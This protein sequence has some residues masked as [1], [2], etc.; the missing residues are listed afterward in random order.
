LIQAR[1]QQSVIDARDR[2]SAKPGPN[3]NADEGELVMRREVVLKGKGLAGS[4]DLT[5]LAP[6]RPG[7]VPA[8]DSVTYA[9]RVKRL[10]QTL[11]AGR[12]SAHEYALVRPLSDAVERVGRIH[13]VRVVLI[14]PDNKVLLSATF[15]GS[16]EAYFRVLWQ[17]TGRLLDVIYCNTVDYVTA[18]DHPYEEWLAWARRVQLETDFFYGVPSATVDDQRFLRDM[19]RR[20][21]RHPASAADPVD[22]DLRNARYVLPS[23]EAVARSTQSDGREDTDD[24]LLAVTGPPQRELVKQSV[25]ALAGLYALTDLYVP[26]TVDGCYLA[27]A[28]VEYLS[29]LPAEYVDR[30]LQDD[31]V[32]HRF[33]RQVNWFKAALK[34]PLPDVRR[35]PKLPPGL[36]AFDADDV[37]GG[38]VTP[39]EG[40]MTHGC[41]LLLAFDSAAAAAAFLARLL[42]PAAPKLSAESGSADPVKRNLSFTLEGLRQCGLDDAQLAMFPDEF[43]HGM[44][45]RAGQIGDLRTNHPRRW[46]RPRRFGAQRA[47]SDDR[48][49]LAAVHALLQLRVA[50][51]A[52]AP[53]SPDDYDVTRPGHPLNK[54]LD[55]L[56]PANCGTRILA[57]ESMRRHFRGV[58]PVE[59]FG[60][61]DEASQPTIDPGAPDANVNRVQLGEM[62]IGYANE[63]DHAPDRAAEPDRAAWLHNGSFLVVRKLRQFVDQ[64][65]KAVGQAAIRPLTAETIYAKLVGRDRDGNS[66]VTGNK[67]NNFTYAF[68]DPEG[69]KCPLHAHIRRANPRATGGQD[70]R[71]MPHIMRRGMSYGRPYDDKL[72]PDSAHNRAERGLVFMAYNASIGE[73]FEVVQRWL[74]GGNSTG[75]SSNPSD[76][77]IGVPENG[78][79]RWFQFEHPE[80]KIVRVALD[81][82]DCMFSDPKPFVRLEWGAYFFAPSMKALRRLRDTATASGRPTLA[83]SVADGERAIQTLLTLGC[84]ARAVVEW[85]RV[86]EDIESVRAFGAASVWAA[87]RANHGGVL[88]TP[89]GVLVADSSLVQRMLDDKHLYSVSGYLERMKKSIGADHLGLDDSGPGCP[90]RQD[91][92]AVNDAITNLNQDEA[93]KVAREAVY[94]KLQQIT[95]DAKSTSR[96]FNDPRFE[97]AFDPRELIDEMLA[98]LCE[99]WFGLEEQTPPTHFQR[100]GMRWDWQRGQPVRYPG[101]FG[102]SSR[103]IFQPH[104]RDEVVR[105]GI[106]HG[107]GVRTA[108][109][110]FIEELR[111]A[112][113]RPTGPVGEAACAPGFP[114]DIDR[115]ARALAGAVMGFVP[116]VEGALRRV[117]GEWTR[118]GTYWHQRALRGGLVFANLAEARRELES[119]MIR[120]LQLRPMPELIWRTATAAHTVSGTDGGCVDVQPDD[121][122][123]LS[124]VSS[125]QQGLAGGDAELAVMFGGVRGADPHPTHACPGRHAGEAAML[126]VLAA[127]VECAHSMRPGAIAPS[128]VIEGDSGIKTALPPVCLTTASPVVS[129]TPG[130]GPEFT[131]QLAALAA[132]STMNATK[133]KTSGSRNGKPR[134]AS[135][136]TLLAWGDSWLCYRSGFL[137]QSNLTK[138]LLAA[139]FTSAPQSPYAE[140]GKKLDSMAGQPTTDQVYEVL[141]FMVGNGTPPKAILLSCGGNDCVKKELLGFVRKSG[142][143]DDI[144]KGAWQSH[145]DKLSAGLVT[146]FGNISEKARANGAKTPINVVLHGYDHPVADGRWLSFGPVPIPHS[147]AWLYGWLVT[148]LGYSIPQATDIMRRLIDGLNSMM[149]KL[150]GAHG[151]VRVKHV[152]LTGTL[153]DKFGRTSTD[154]P[155]QDA[156]WFA[157]GYKLA[158]ENELH[159]VPAGFRLFAE[160]LGAAIDELSP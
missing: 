125:L 56:V 133:K 109:R 23:V 89:Y 15:D 76:P 8:L 41:A 63:A 14:E 34:E 64:L 77:L 19:E 142:A 35:A 70:G 140:V 36:P 122:V 136:G 96:E 160:K 72:P 116:T 33:E 5:L 79:Q 53:T 40:P 98:D 86:L 135:R 10:L 73:Q 38:I 137:A 147:T 105:Y 84:G 66:L 121:V 17:K 80:N 16:W 31:R 128:L 65:Q 131:T 157:T 75:S 44:A 100:G 29:E 130:S 30:E 127:L 81:G 26:D 112:G 2:P 97:V 155:M 46:A 158:W 139:G 71:R 94:R 134:S 154:Q 1:P 156:E 106:D 45:A 67:N 104:P 82:S 61:A 150:T 87:I 115:A 7:F 18:W 149:A 47:A 129:T 68:S 6:V 101:H 118:D 145:L 28:A 74:A 50:H 141:G 114:I 51:S 48:I 93:F 151:L 27:R 83:W 55:L 24:G 11:H 108:M 92:K 88:R 59:H 126:G 25:Q 39:Y 110:E 37:Q 57:A 146:I 60:Y 21:I 52:A 102:A 148:D 120:A 4:S 124:L 13:S 54:E 62:L 58:A 20:S 159:P 95:D 123:V 99:R 3:N 113:K 103:Y 111:A 69:K 42:D 138:E 49:D 12:A 9:S 85:K 107:V 152:D 43:R 117:L 90:Y 119:P 144:D 32:Q 153:R 91:S 143:G 78:R 132:T 22:V